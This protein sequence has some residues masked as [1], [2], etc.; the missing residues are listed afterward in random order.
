ML[1]GSFSFRMTF[2][3][4]ATMNS[5]N[6]DYFIHGA[7]VEHGKCAEAISLVVRGTVRVT[8]GE[9]V[10]GELVAGN[11]VGSALL[12]SGVPADVDAM[13]VEPV[14]TVRW[15]V[16]TLERYLT[17]NPETRIIMQRHLARDLARKMDLLTK[18]SPT[19]T[20]PDG[21]N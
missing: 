20:D 1:A 10:L 2:P 13:V 21:K 14:R 12:L 18:G 19:T 3:W 5:F 11:I 9:R 17:A 16:G 15:E 7:N 6:P 8:R 4:G